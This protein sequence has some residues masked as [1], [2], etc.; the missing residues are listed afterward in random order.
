MNYHSLNRFTECPSS[1]HRYH[2]TVVPGYY[3]LGEMDSCVQ[4]FWKCQ[5]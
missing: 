1:L 2:W 4:T 3:L 5:V